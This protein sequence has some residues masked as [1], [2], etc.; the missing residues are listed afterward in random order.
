MG[1]ELAERERLSELVTDERAP[2]DDGDLRVRDLRDHRLRLVEVLEVE[3]RLRLVGAIRLE[4]VG[5]ATGGDEEPVVPE[6]AARVGRHGLVL[7]VDLDDLRLEAE[8]DAVVVVPRLVADVHALLEEHA[9][10]VARE[11]DAVVQGVRLVVDHHDLAGNVVLAELLSR[12]RACGAVADDHEAS[13]IRAQD[14]PP[15]RSAGKCGGSL[16]AVP[17]EGFEPS[18]Y[19]F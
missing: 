15:K 19:G 13:G 2:E 9:L 7:K 1:L 17:V 8:V 5:P 18:L 16:V 12:V 6:F 3:D 4:R 10:Q 11:R 14:V